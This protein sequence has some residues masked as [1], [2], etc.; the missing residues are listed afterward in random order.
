MLICSFTEMDSKNSGRNVYDLFPNIP[1][2]YFSKYL[3][4]LTNSKILQSTDFNSHI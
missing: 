1:Q 3:K 2:S 4:F